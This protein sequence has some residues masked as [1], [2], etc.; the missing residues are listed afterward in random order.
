[1]DLSLRSRMFSARPR[2]LCLELELLCSHRAPT[3]KLL[4][5]LF[6]LGW[7]PSF[8]QHPRGLVPAHGD[9][10]IKSKRISKSSKN[11]V[12]W[13]YLPFLQV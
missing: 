7:K 13:T 2:P 9:R 8:P 5:G 10:L 6:R 11:R 4:H 1:M 12:D 3:A